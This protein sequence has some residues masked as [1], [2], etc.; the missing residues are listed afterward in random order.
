MLV[1]TLATLAASGAACAALDGVVGLI[2]A[3]VLFL[4]G[5]GL[6]LVW[7]ARRVFPYEDSGA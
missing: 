3:G 6:T 5:A 7:E 4:A 1:G 2:L